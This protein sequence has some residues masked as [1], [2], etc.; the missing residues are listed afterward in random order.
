MN[1][2]S[3]II[4]IPKNISESDTCI[5]LHQRDKSVP[6]VPSTVRADGTNETRKS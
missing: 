5:L 2:G 1:E 3:I 4:I 6:I